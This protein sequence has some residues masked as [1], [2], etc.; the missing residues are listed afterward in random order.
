[1]SFIILFLPLLFS[2]WKGDV[3]YCLWHDYWPMWVDFIS[4]ISLIPNRSFQ[5][6]GSTIQ[7]HSTAQFHECSTSCK[8]R[9]Q[10]MP[11]L[12]LT[13]ITMT[14]SPILH[15]VLSLLSIVVSLMPCL[16]VIKLITTPALRN[17]W[18][19]SISIKGRG[20]MNEGRKGMGVMMMRMRMRMTK[21]PPKRE[22][23]ARGG[24]QKKRNVS[25][26]EDSPEIVISSLMGLLQ[27]MVP[28]KRSQYKEGPLKVI[29]DCWVSTWGDF[30]KE[31]KRTICH[32]PAQNRRNKRS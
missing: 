7:G 8:K 10:L 20:G 13:T 23:R 16:Q 15:L 27:E 30:A 5:Y 4:Q 29:A 31:L 21:S 24:L 1:M 17:L 28:W 11:T 22:R 2:Y 18:N 32:E 19:V 14:M 6:S 26:D 9:G 25:D 3:R 12:V